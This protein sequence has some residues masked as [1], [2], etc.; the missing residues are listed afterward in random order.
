M[1]KFGCHPQF[2]AASGHSP[3]ARN[4]LFQCGECSCTNELLH[5]PLELLRHF[6][7]NHSSAASNLLCSRTN[8]LFVDEDPDSMQRHCQTHEY[9]D[10]RAEHDSEGRL[11]ARCDICQTSEVFL[12]QHRMLE[13]HKEMSFFSRIRPAPRILPPRESLPSDLEESPASTPTSQGGNQQHLNGK[14]HEKRSLQTAVGSTNPSRLQRTDTASYA[15]SLLQLPNKLQ[16]PRCGP[17]KARDAGQSFRLSRK[18]KHEPGFESLPQSRQT[19]SMAK[20]RPR[21]VQIAEAARHEKFGQLP[22]KRSA[23]P[24]VQN[25]E[26]RCK[27]SLGTVH[28]PIDLSDDG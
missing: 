13:W 26:K 22:W 19:A 16:F 4:T 17:I 18:E 8:C 9:Y 15:T 23:S 3:T 20:W 25:R 21:P 2:S 7:A 14:A 24:V 27:T 10:T 5:D 12:E 11:L 6:R 1:V 28:A